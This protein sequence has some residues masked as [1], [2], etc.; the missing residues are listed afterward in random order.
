MQRAPQIL[1]DIYEE[2]L[3]EAAFLHGVWEEAL[4]GANYAVNDVVIGPEERLLAHLDGLVLGGKRVADKLLVPALADEEVGKVFAAAWVLLQAED[5]DHW[6]LVAEALPSAEPPARAGI[7]RALTLSHRPDLAKKTAALWEKSDALIRGIILDVVAPRDLAWAHERLAPCLS[8]RE[9]PLLAAALRVAQRLPDAAFVP[10]IEDAL[11]AEDASVR[12]GAI[13]AAFLR[14]L[15]SGWDAC[16]REAQ[17]QGD[18]CRLPLAL[19]ALR[20]DTRDSVLAQLTVPEMRRHAAWALGFAG[21]TEAA[22][23]LVGLLADEAVARVAGESLSAITGLVIAGP[24]SVP[25][26]TKGP[27]VEEVGLDDPPPEVRPEDHLPVPNAE[28]VKK[29]WDRTRG[30]LPA[31]TRYIYGRSGGVEA[32]R[33]A[34]PGAAMWRRAALFLD[35][36]AATRTPVPVDLRGW[37]RGQR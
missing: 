29:W 22:D 10:H 25:G 3:D 19:L 17:V 37:A 5:A 36:A 34:L 23:V 11:R 35:V 13:T 33:A 31:G 21:D 28:A 7:A 9:A 18:G 26:V 30:Q 4:V 20:H 6:D 27:D 14:A 15:P 12:A 24:L 32:V 8:S 16:R 2:H 1:W